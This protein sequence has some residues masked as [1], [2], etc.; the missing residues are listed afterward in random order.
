MKL[1]GGCRMVKAVP[2]TSK[3][4]WLNLQNVKKY[5][6]YNTYI[7][8]A[9][10]ISTSRISGSIKVKSSETSHHLSSSFDFLLG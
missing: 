10:N 7:T 2:M 9:R 5:G 4:H 3:L 1:D 6:N 8:T